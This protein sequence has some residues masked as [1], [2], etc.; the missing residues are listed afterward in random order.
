MLEIPTLLLVFTTFAYRMSGGKKGKILIIDDNEELLIALKLILSPHFEEIVTKKNPNLIPSLILENTF[1]VILLDM[2]FSA[3]IQTGNEGIYWMN[4]ILEQDSSA[5]VVFITAY[6]DVELA[7]KSLKEGATDFIQKSW[8]EQKILSTVLSAFKHRLSK[9]EIIN[10]RNKQEHLKEKLESNYNIC[11]GNSPVMQEVFETIGKVAKTDVNVLLLGENG[12]GKEVIAREIHRKSN[13]ANEIFVS[14]DVGTL[15]ETLFESELFGY[16]KGAFTDANEDKAGRFEIA[17]G[18]TLFLDEIG[19]LSL[20]LQSKLL[21]AI[22]NRE[23]IRLGSNA[24]LSVDIR[25]ICATNQPIAEMVDKGNFREDLMYR[26]NT[27]QIEIPALRKRIEDIPVLSRFFLSQYMDKYKRHKLKLSPATLQT[28]QKHRW[29]G[30]IRELQHVI[31]KAVILTD[32]NVIEPENLLLQSRKILPDNP[33]VF[34]L[35]ENEKEL[36][37]T[38]LEK[39][40]GNISLTAKE[41]GINRSTLYEKIKKYEI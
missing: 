1:D 23:I 37:Q 24:P 31:E 28:L 35:A 19:N 29:P 11:I 30:N 26:I 39:F 15:S 14:V 4:K 22:Q 27:V 34:N 7:V 21:S 41:L 10:L 38:A 20:S 25:L 18:G 13:R 32:S 8:D 36:I 17:S 33:V 9:L 40:R 5:T 2:N 12:T 3:G 16:I 6:G